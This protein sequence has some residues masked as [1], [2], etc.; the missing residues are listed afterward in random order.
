MQPR[1]GHIGK[2]RVRSWLWVF[3]V[4]RTFV[5]WTHGGFIGFSRPLLLL[6]TSFAV[7]LQYVVG[8]WIASWASLLYYVLLHA[9]SGWVDRFVAVRVLLSCGCQCGSNNT[10]CSSS[11]TAVG[12]GC[13][14]AD[15]LVFVVCCWGTSNIYCCATD[16][17][18]EGGS[19][20]SFLW[21][22]D[23]MCVHGFVSYPHF[24]FFS[25]ATPAP[26]WHGSAYQYL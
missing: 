2:T 11:C 5:F 13:G 20:G 25:P 8:G 12:Q 1:T 26:R 24:C 9:A 19:I 6:Y 16:Y 15:R 22:V 21:C 23:G 18:A 3:D 4:F 17:S 7:L 10:Y 14:W